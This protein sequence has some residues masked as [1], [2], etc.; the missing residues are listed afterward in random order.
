MDHITKLLTVA[1]PTYNRSSSLRAMLD[2]LTE[3]IR[4]FKNDVE[5]IISDN[6][7]TDNTSQVIENWLSRQSCDI[8]VT[9]IKQ[10]KNIGVSKNIVSLIYNASADYFMF[11]G[12]DDRIDRRNF[13]DI[14][15][16]LRNHRPSAVIQGVWG[17]KLRSSSVGRIN[18]NEAAS[19]FY[20]YGN[21]WAG[22]VDRDA[23]IAA[24]ESRALRDQIEKIVWPQTVF[25]Y[26]A[27]LDL[28]STR[29]IFVVNFEMGR[30]MGDA[31]NITNKAYWMR[32]LAD[33]L[34]AA[35]IVQRYTRNT[36][37]S[38]RFISFK[39]KGFT[40]HIKS[41][42]WYSLVDSDQSSLQPIAQ[43]LSSQFGW[44]GW[45]WSKILLLDRHPRALEFFSKIIFHLFWSKGGESLK[46][47]MAE[48]RNLRKIEIST[49][50]A[51][52][53]RFGDWF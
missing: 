10:I 15:D 32:S 16:I 6:C 35:S 50:S 42:F 34:A 41:I 12:D 39:S 7:S 53:K 40:S 43:T 18:F 33:L 27:M 24:I 19:L 8:S 1:I 21:A 14:L 48:E 46:S 49:K 20:E 3:D 26:L 22:L 36:N 2:L 30:P 51:S 44:R 4:E 28:S 47:R 25:G 23:A 11:L 13:P 52:G 29:P 38:K 9:V 31:L 37:L 5:I 17:G 45:I